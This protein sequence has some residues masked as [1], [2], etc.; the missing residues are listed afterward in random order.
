MG[1]FIWALPQFSCR[2][3]EKVDA[4]VSPR[5][6]HKLNRAA[7]K[8]ELGASVHLPFHQFQT[9]NLVFHLAVLPCR[10]IGNYIR[11][12]VRWMREIICLGVLETFR[13]WVELLQLA[14]EPITD[15]SEVA[16][17]RGDPPDIDIGMKILI[18]SSS[19]CR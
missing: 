3:K 8:L 11:R 10:K 12:A 19:R 17:V 15:I 14:A 6:V 13:S 18:F 2:F 5:Q 1:E 4:T 16:E 9:V 7:Q